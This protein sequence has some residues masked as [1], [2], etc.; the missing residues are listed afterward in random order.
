MGLGDRAR[1]IPVPH[2]RPGRP[3]RYRIRHGPRRCGHP[4]RD[5]SGALPAGELPRRKI[6]AHRQSRT[7]RPAVDRH[8][9]SG[10]HGTGPRSPIRG[11]VTWPG[12]RWWS[13]GGSVPDPALTGSALPS[14]S[15]SPRTLM[16][17]SR[18][19]SRTKGR[20][21]RTSSRFGWSCWTGA[22]RDRYAGGHTRP[23][24]Y[25]LLTPR[26]RKGIRRL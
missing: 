6:R 11:W 21:R 19:P 2:P 24:H 23:D 1:R 25:R 10:P 16:A 9:G 20:C 7:H 8:C 17:L 26:Y 14:T 5:D 4:R 12:A 15:N 22:R 3:V 13:T 18:V